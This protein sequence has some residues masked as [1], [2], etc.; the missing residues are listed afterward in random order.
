MSKKKQGKILSFLKK[1]IQ[2]EKEILKK[3]NDS[4]KELSS[5]SGSS[6]S[7]VVEVFS[8]D[9]KSKEKSCEDH[10]IKFKAESSITEKTVSKSFLDDKCIKK[11]PVQK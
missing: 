10:E 11:V 8:S 7:S 5:T 2:V 3:S 9:L 6:S 4:E 1:P